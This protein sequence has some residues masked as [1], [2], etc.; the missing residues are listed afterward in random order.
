MIPVITPEVAVRRMMERVVRQRG[1]PSPYAASRKA[2][3]TSRSIS[4][5]VREMVGIIMI[6]NATP[7]AKAEKCFW[8]RTTMA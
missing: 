1:M 7:P 2:C 6:A 5:V 4:S 3:G 8:E